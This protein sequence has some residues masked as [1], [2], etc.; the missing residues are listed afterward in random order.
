VDFRKLNVEMKK[1]PFPL[2]FTDEVLNTM[3]RWILFIFGWMFLAPKDIYKTTLVINSLECSLE[4]DAF[5]SEEWSSNILKS[6]DKKNL[7]NIWTISWRYFYMIS[8]YIVTW[9]LICKS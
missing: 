5:W 8:Q 4:G 2:P 3:T 7:D 6:Y 1:D 9:W